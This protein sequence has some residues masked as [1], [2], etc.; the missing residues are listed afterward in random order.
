MGDSY[1]NFLNKI[2]A[3]NYA[4]SRGPTTNNI[5]LNGPNSFT[6]IPPPLQREM[7]PVSPIEDDI[8]IC[9]DSIFEK[10]G[11]DIRYINGTTTLSNLKVELVNDNYLPLGI[12]AQYDI[13]NVLIPNSNTFPNIN[14]NSPIKCL[15]FK[16][17][18][19]ISE[20]YLKLYVSLNIVDPITNTAGHSIFFTIYDGN[21]PLYNYSFYYNR[22]NTGSYANTIY[23]ELY[24]TVSANT[25]KEYNLYATSTSL[26]CN[27]SSNVGIYSNINPV[28]PSYITIEDVG[29]FLLC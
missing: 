27:I 11:N 10:T 9:K 13:M 28:G 19:P 20:R 16:L 8:H 21:E 23:F 4:T 18:A 7:L 5:L 29:G 15:K 24:T 22:S 12:I 26:S 25:N 17:D 3:Q 2:R 6:C 1:G 14:S